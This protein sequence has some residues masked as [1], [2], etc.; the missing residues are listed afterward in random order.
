[1]NDPI[2]TAMGRENLGKAGLPTNFEDWLK[3][4]EEKTGGYVKK[5]LY[6]RHFTHGRT[7]EQAI[8]LVKADVIADE[9]FREVVRRSNEAAK[10]IAPKAFPFGGAHIAELVAIKIEQAI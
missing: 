8:E 9:I 6:G 1:M 5:S 3:L 10:K 7:I 4:V 2:L